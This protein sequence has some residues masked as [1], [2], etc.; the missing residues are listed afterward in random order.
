MAIRG[1]LNRQPIEK[2]Q[3]S[4]VATIFQAE[5]AFSGV[6]SLLQRKTCSYKGSKP[7]SSKRSFRMSSPIFFMPA[8]V[9][10]AMRAIASVLP[11][12]R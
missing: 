8:C 9:A 3:A 1:F 11:C 5:K 4:Q 7:E 10:L 6:K 12:L 2:I